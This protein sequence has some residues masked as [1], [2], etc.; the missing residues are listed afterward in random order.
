MSKSNRKNTKKPDPKPWQKRNAELN[1]GVAWNWFREMNDYG[2]KTAWQVSQER[3]DYFAKKTD[4]A[5]EAWERMQEETP[6]PEEMARKLREKRY[7]R[8]EKREDDD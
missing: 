6:P 1:E 7:E 3:K 2:N 5:L 8:N 4:Q